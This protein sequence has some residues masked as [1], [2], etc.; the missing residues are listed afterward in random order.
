MTR[1]E[2][3]A[4]V[5]RALGL[6][7]SGAGKDTFN[8]VTKADWYYDAVSIAY[9]YG[10]ISGCG[11]QEFGPADKVTREQAMIMIARAMD[12]TGLKTE[13]ANAEAN[14]L[15]ENFVDAGE[16]ADYA[17]NS[18]AVNMKAGIVTGRKGKTL[19][20]KGNI[21]RAEIAVIIRRL[22][23]TSGLI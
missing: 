13:L 21:T 9:E 22:L 3:A 23:Q 12:I 2:F 8:D 4:T 1:A 5:V 20:P 10:I 7:R 18:V 19:A 16:T 15:L 11:G 17:R 14:K 6:M